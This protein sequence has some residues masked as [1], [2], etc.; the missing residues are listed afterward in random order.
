MVDQQVSS[1]GQIWRMKKECLNPD[2]DGDGIISTDELEAVLHN[3]Q[4]KLH[5][6]DDDVQ[7]AIKSTDLD[8]N[9][10]VNLGEYYANQKDK[11]SRNLLHHA[12]IDSSLRNLQRIQKV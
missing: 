2:Q 3:I 6:T 1:K 4:L 7:A 8:G 10:T 5:A 9:G 11:S 12:L